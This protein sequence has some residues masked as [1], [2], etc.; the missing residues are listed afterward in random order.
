M[1]FEAVL[2]LLLGQGL[3]SVA[4]G[5]VPVNRP[6]VLDDAA[7]HLQSMTDTLLFNTSLREFDRRR[8]YQDPLELDWYSNGC[9]YSPDNP[10]GYPFLQACRRHDFGYQNYEQQNRFTKSAKARIDAQFQKEYAPPKTCRVSIDE[11]SSSVPSSLSTQ[12]RYGNSSVIRCS[13][14][15]SLY[16]EAAR[17]AGGPHAL[18]EAS[19]SVR[20]DCG[21]VL[22]NVTV[23]H[24]YQKTRERAFWPRIERHQESAPTAITFEDRPWYRFWGSSRDQWRAS[25]STED[26]RL[27]CYTRP[28]FSEYEVHNLDDRDQ[29]GLIVISV[30]DIV[31]N[32]YEIRNA[33]LPPG[34]SNESAGRWACVSVS[35]ILSGAVEPDDDAPML[36]RVLQSGYFSK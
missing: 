11:C 22:V 12:C 23:E 4:A 3:C 19:V 21:R 26:G 2:W 33:R 10:W 35:D 28:L 27:F 30:S 29:D 14:M 25:W 8:L 1:R 5:L 31:R 32:R 15:A 20:N 36:D 18:D 13:R 7:R 16:Y 9:S 34:K 6:P 24:M 17:E